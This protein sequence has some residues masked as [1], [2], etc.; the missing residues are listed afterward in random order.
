[1]MKNEK[2]L[3]RE[4]NHCEMKTTNGGTFNFFAY[5]MGYAIG[6]A[7]A[8]VEGAYSSGYDSAQNNCEC[9]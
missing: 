9:N 6:T 7:V 5:A 4:M 8:I 3:L 2:S 1:M